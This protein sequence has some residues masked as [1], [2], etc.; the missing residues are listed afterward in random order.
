MVLLYNKS[1]M[2]KCPYC[3]E[4]IKDLAIKCKHCWE[5]LKKW[6]TKVCPFCKKEIEED[7]EDC[8]FC[9]RSLV[10]KTSIGN[11]S[12]ERRVPVN[13]N[14]QPRKYIFKNIFN[15]ILGIAARYK[16]LLIIIGL[17]S[18]G[19]ISSYLSNDKYEKSIDGTINVIN[20]NVKGVS[21]FEW[22]KTDRHGEEYNAY[23]YS[24]KDLNISLFYEG[25]VNLENNYNGFIQSSLAKKESGKTFIRKYK[26]IFLFIITELVDRAYNDQNY[27]DANFYLGKIK[28]Q[29]MDAKFSSYMASINE[30]DSFRKY[31]ESTEQVVKNIQINSKLKTL[32]GDLKYCETACSVSRYNELVNEYNWL[33][34]QYVKKANEEMFSDSMNMVEVSIIFPLQKNKIEIVDVKN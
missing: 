25:L 17:A 28:Y 4:D 3:H 30:V 2:K 33:L 21:E 32:D 24:N 7:A 18:I 20:Q 23:V 34:G 5:R 27:D 6:W 26:T 29:M 16:F 9:G 22:V 31:I 14:K 15:K 12:N 13:D 11:S 8:R 10:E 1:L 19:T